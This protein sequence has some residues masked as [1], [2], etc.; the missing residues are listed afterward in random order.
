MVSLALRTVQDVL[1]TAKLS[2]SERWALE[3]ACDDLR[4]VLEAPAQRW[5]LD[6]GQ[7]RNE[8][9]EAIGSFP[10]TLG[11]PEDRANAQLACAAP[12]LAGALQGLLKVLEHG[13]EQG[14]D[15]DA[16]VQEAV[17]ALDLATSPPEV[18][19]SRRLDESEAF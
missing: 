18:Q 1:H 4:A 5:R 14:G 10:Y 16:A 12:E 3:R 17:R 8:R 19:R 9:G 15:F 7:L 11:G 13:V 6:G 2:K